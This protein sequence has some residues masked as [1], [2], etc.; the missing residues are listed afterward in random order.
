VVNI[1]DEKGQSLTHVAVDSRNF[2]S[3]QV[4]NE[5]G[6]V[7][8]H[9]NLPD[10]YG[11]TPLHISAINFD[12]E[13]FKILLSYGPNHELTDENG[14]TFVQYL[15]ENEELEQFEEVNKILNLM[16]CII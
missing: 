12:L 14:M 7:K 11:M 16:N 13:I 5:L 10:N 9:I 3:V 1:R 4:L 6:V 2:S 15:K 8:N